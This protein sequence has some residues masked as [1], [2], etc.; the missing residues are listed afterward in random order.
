[1]KIRT[2]FVSNSSSSS[3]VCDVSGEAFEVHDGCFW[4]AGLCQ[5]QVGHIFKKEFL[6]KWQRPYPSKEEMLAFLDERTDSKRE[7]AKYRSLTDAQLKQK[8]LGE[9]D[10]Y[11]GNNSHVNECPICTLTKL[12]DDMLLMYMFAKHG[13]TREGTAA[14]IRKEFGSFEA[15]KRS[16]LGQ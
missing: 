1:M 3:Y 15:F 12:G 14:E 2:G 13:G 11:Q 9:K 16:V 4:D 8:F 10:G 6:V 7:C 5:C